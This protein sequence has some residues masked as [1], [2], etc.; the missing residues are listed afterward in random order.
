VFHVPGGRPPQPGGCLSCG[1]P[2]ARGSGASSA[3]WRRGW[4]SG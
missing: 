4:P 1:D 3:R 2:I